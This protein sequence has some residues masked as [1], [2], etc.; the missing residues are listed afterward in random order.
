MI[1][2]ERAPAGGEPATSEGGPASAPG[3]PL[4]L[5]TATLEQ[6]DT[7]DGV[8]PATA[9]KILAYREEHGGFSNVDELGEIPGIG[10]KRLASL[11]E[12]VQV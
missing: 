6:L 8:G 10:E 1:V 11:R 3:Q 2:P 4:N 7:L 5:N 12:Q 9:E